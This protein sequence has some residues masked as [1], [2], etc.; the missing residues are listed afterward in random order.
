MLTCLSEHVRATFTGVH[1]SAP[2]LTMERDVITQFM[3]KQS[4][5]SWREKFS[6]FLSTCS[7][8]SCEI[9]AKRH[10]LFVGSLVLTAF[11]SSLTEKQKLKGLIS[12]QSTLIM[13]SYRWCWSWWYLQCW[14]HWDE[15]FNKWK[16]LF[17]KP[18]AEGSIRVLI[19]NRSFAISE[20]HSSQINPRTAKW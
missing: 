18:F 9:N 3:R 6:R 5:I 14:I 19:D 10:W 17:R 12:E 13:L 15:N 16:G 4:S 8:R 11:R 20:K 7:P 1:R 2:L